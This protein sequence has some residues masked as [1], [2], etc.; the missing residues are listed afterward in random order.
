MEEEMTYVLNL[1]DVD[2][3]SLSLVGGKNASLGEMISAG[4]RVPPGFAVTTDSYLS[5]VIK[6]GINDRVL[7]ALSDLNPDDV[8]ALNDASARVQDM[9]KSAPMSDEVKTAIET[10]YAGLCGEC[11]VENV[12]VAVRSSATAEVLFMGMKLT[13]SSTGIIGIFS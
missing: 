4:I 11:S 2:K 9:I 7:Q 1:K 5:F 8:N 6:T 10:G 13:W 12:P 3:D